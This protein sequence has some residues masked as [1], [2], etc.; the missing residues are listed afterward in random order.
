MAE[1]LKGNIND[2]KTLFRMMNGKCEKLKSIKGEV[3]D[4]IGYA[5]IRQLNAKETEEVEILYILLEDGRICATNSP[6]VRRTFDAM[7]TAFGEPTPEKP[8]EEIRVFEAQSKN[9][10]TYLDIDFAD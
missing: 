6:T 10:R 1:I 2:A 4:I 5:I 7:V 3:I 9:D 8:L